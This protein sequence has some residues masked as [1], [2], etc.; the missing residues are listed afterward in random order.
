MRFACL[1]REASQTASQGALGAHR[2]NTARVG[3]RSHVCL[4]VPAFHRA[5]EAASLLSNGPHL[6]IKVF[7]EARFLHC[8][9]CLV[10]TLDK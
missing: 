8:A 2:P 7:T 1:V 9:S 4:Q 10:Y 3:V 5:S 6:I